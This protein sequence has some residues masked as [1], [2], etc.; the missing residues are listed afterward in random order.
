MGDE[1]V[2]VKPVRKIGSV[3]ESLETAL[4]A[5]ENTAIVIEDMKA[6]RKEY[7]SKELSWR[8]VDLLFILNETNKEV[9]RV[10]KII[11]KKVLSKEKKTTVNKLVEIKGDELVKNEEERVNELIEN[12]EIERQ[13][14]ESKNKKGSKKDQ[15]VGDSDKGKE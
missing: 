14:I 2:V 12:D 6:N 8:N 5:V 3:R 9:L 1:K 15:E 10:V 4:K 7:G 13:K 11:A